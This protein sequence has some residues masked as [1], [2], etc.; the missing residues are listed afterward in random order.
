MQVLVCEE[1][2]AALLPRPEKLNII[3]GRTR[4]VW[5]LSSFLPC[6]ARHQRSL[7]LRVRRGVQGG[8]LSGLGVWRGLLS[9]SNLVLCRCIYQKGGSEGPAGAKLGA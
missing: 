6:S 1:L 2:T 9:R 8:H 7:R 3:T 4:S 5:K